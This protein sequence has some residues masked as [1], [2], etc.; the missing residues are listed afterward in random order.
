MDYCAYSNRE[1]ELIADD[2]NRRYDA[3]R[4][5]KPKTVDVYDVIDMVGARIAIDYLTPDRSVL[6]ATVLKTSEVYVWPGSPYFTGMLPRLRMYRKGTIIIDRSLNESKLEQDR[7][8]ENFTAIHECFHVTRHMGL[9][10]DDCIYETA[11]A[12]SSRLPEKGTVRY[13]L[14]RQADYAAA[15]FLMP[16]EAV[17]KAAEEV[18]GVRGMVSFCRAVKPQI[19][20]LGRL[21]GVNGTPMEYRLQ[22]LGLLSDYISI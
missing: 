20:E 18:F 17:C 12:S 19:K 21:F 4:L 6:G 10:L 2:L 14:E 8:V 1:L 3:T 22:E 5:T 11:P 13:R 16:R 9:D 7:F 15:A